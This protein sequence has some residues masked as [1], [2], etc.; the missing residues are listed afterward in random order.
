M[1]DSNDKIL[2]YILLG[3][4]VGGFLTYII[5][6]FSNQLTLLNQQLSIYNSS[7]V[8]Q[9]QYQY[10]QVYQPQPTTIEPTSTPK[11]IPKRLYNVQFD[12]EGFITDLNS[13]Q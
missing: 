12:G 6:S 7:L 4:V 3:A 11:L 10:P 8:Y 2:E 9:Q 13:T 5:V 1:T